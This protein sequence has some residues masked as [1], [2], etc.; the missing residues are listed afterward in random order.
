[1]V[2]PPWIPDDVDAETHRRIARTF[3]VLRL[4]RGGLLVVFLAVAMVAIE[5]KGWPRQATVLVGLVM[6][7]LVAS[8]IASWRRYSVSA[9]ESSST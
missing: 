9:W 7:L 5:F 6:V 4:V 3:L 1:M 2:P 8:L